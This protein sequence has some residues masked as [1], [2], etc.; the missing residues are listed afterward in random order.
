MMNDEGNHKLFKVCMPNF[1]L[2]GVN[3]VIEGTYELSS[4]HIGGDIC[5]PRTKY[6]ELLLHKK[7]DEN[8]N[9]ST[10]STAA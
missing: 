9:N 6:I 7:K 4:D 3:F 5:K 1:D 10:N 8:K 2:S